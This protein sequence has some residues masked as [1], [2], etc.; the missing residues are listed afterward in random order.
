MR[1]WQSEENARGSQRV[2]SFQSSCKEVKAK[3]ETSLV[4]NSTHIYNLLR[5]QVLNKLAS[6]IFNSIKLCEQ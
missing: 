5:Q 6:I 3:K 2:K 4:K 1:P